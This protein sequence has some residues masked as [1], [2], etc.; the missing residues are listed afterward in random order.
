MISANGKE[1]ISLLFIFKSV[2]AP[3]TQLLENA[4]DTEGLARKSCAKNVV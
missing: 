2:F 3:E 1:E 4:C